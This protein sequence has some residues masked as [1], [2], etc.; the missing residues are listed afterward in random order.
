M[1]PS[2]RPATSLLPLLV[3]LALA[4]LAAPALADTPVMSVDE[5]QRFGFGSAGSHTDTYTVTLPKEGC[6]IVSDAYCSG[7]QFRVTINGQD[8]GL[9]SAPA[10]AWCAAQ[11]GSNADEAL[12]K[13]EYSK[14]YFPINGASSFIISV[15]YTQGGG[16]AYF[17]ISSATCPAPFKVVT[18]AGK[19]NSR[20]AAAAACEAAGM[21]LA[22]VTSA[23]WESVLNVVRASPD[24]KINPM[25]AVVIN[26]WNSD[27]YGGVNLQLTVSS[28]SGAITLLTGPAY[29]LC[30][31]PVPALV[32]PTA[33]LATTSSFAAKKTA[34]KDLNNGLPAGGK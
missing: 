34:P 18:S 10:G 1:T 20:A 17:K 2:T 21:A 3:L 33:S 16:G 12:T 32:T 8:K 9:T 31:T 5:W 14:G 11:V 19:V 4:A 27:T 23:N 29:P 22:D 7:D 26:S 30:Q 24:I 15:V 28:T 6:L 25:D 13:P